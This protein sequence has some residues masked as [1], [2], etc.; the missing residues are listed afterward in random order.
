VLDE[1]EVY[2]FFNVI[3]VIPDGFIV[4]QRVTVVVPW[5]RL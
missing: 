4:L 1:E 2:H 3:P 5:T